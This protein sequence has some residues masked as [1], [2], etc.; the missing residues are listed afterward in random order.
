LF[1]AVDQPADFGVQLVE[2][3]DVFLQNGGSFGQLLDLLVLGNIHFAEPLQLGLLRLGDIYGV[4]IMDEGAQRQNHQDA[5]GGGGDLQRF[6]WYAQTES[7]LAV[8]GYEHQCIFTS[9]GRSLFR[10]QTLLHDGVVVPC[11]VV[12]LFPNRQYIHRP[13]DEKCD[14]QL[15]TL[16]FSVM[17]RLSCYRLENISRASAMAFFSS[18]VRK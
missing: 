3:A 10:R 1:V 8:M 7:A 6:D 13:F 4:S 18:A 17:D 12:S 14:Y 16:I 2:P 5:H 15:S 11:F 9:I